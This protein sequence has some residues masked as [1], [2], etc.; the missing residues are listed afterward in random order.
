VNECKPLLGGGHVGPIAGHGE[1]RHCRGR[2]VQDDPIKLK[3][4]PLG[5]ERLKLKSDVL[6]STSAFNFNLCR[7]TVVAALDRRR[8]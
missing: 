5:T 8:A 4:K 1:Y 3:L 2:A 7:Y 6:L